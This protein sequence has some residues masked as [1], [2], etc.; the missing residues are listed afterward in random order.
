M[1]HEQWLP[2]LFESAIK[3]HVV[4]VFVAAMLYMFVPW[5][6]FG[7]FII[8]FSFFL[9]WLKKAFDDLQHLSEFDLNTCLIF[10]DSLFL[11][12]LVNKLQLN[13]SK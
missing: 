13:L 5:P 1:M 11:A 9:F 2:F 10:F 6:I 3:A 8:A 12:W 7:V 4:P